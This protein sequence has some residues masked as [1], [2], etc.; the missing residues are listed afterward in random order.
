MKR[1]ARWPN[2]QPGIEMHMGRLAAPD[3]PFGVL[4]QFKNRRRPAETCELCGRE[5][6]PEHPHLLEIA[7]RK[8]LCSCDG[9]AL[10]FSNQVDARY[11]RVP[12]QIRWLSDFQISDA[13]W[14]GLL[15]PINMAFFFKNSC[16]STVTVLYPSPAGATESLL[17]FDHWNEIVENNPALKDMEPDVEALLVNRVGYG[18]STGSAEYYLLPID[19]CY[20][21]TG[22]IRLHWRG[23]SGGTEVWQEIA[24]FFAHLRDAAT[25][26]GREPNARA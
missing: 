24:K 1:P 18:R 12:R 23:L 15:I 9:C 10:L 2:T 11:K 7:V 4:R 16:E 25:V 21:L 6:M 17:T 5:I 20:K 14:D 3:S 8:L 22:L 26:T 19:E 13:D